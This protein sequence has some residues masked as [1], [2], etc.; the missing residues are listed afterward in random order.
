MPA[1]VDMMLSAVRTQVCGG[2]RQAF[3]ELS[4]EILQQ[5]YVLSKAQ[6]LAHIVAVELEQQGILSA[7]DG[8]IAGKFRKQQMI[9]VLRYE[10]I[11]YELEAICRLLEQEQIPHMPLKGSVLRRYYPEAW[12]RTSA[13]IDIL[14]HTKDMEQAVQLLTQQLEYRQEISGTDYDLSL[15]SPSGVHLELHYG[16]ITEDRAINSHAILADIWKFSQPE[17]SWQYRYLTRDDMFYFYHMAHTVKHFENSG[18][19]V[20]FFLD[21][22]LLN[23]R[24]IFNQ[25]QRDKLLIKG[26]LLEFSKAA[27]MLAEV[28]FG[29]AEHNNLTHAMES[30]VFR[31]GIYGTESNR[32]VTQKIKKGGTVGYAL[33]RI[34]PPYSKMKHIYP[35]LEKRK[36]MLPFFQVRRWCRIVFCGGLKHSMKEIKSSADIDE[37]VKEDT[38]SML[39]TLGLLS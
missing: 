36:W 27:K 1:A 35:S 21:L 26:G 10:R 20:R 3:G 11:N 24:V 19:G 16:M 17:F 25:E 29:D 2:E 5:L 9:A 12:M 30:Y 7:A 6:D 32:M 13:D 22:W 31:G 15:F 33:S 23:H 28:W 4:S 38:Q 39:R 37:S 34:C 18:C 8:E 14:V